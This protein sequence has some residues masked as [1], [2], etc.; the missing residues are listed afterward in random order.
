VWTRS[1]DL[2]M[3]RCA[4]DLNFLDGEPFAV[5]LPT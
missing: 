2:D 3:G 1:G 5:G 4:L